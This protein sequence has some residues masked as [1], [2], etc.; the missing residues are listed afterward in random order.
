MEALVLWQPRLLTNDL[1]STRAL[2][3]TKKT[4]MTATLNTTRMSVKSM[5][6]SLGMLT[7]MR[8]WK[9]NIK[10]MQRF[11]NRV[12]LSVCLCFVCWSSL[13]V[14]CLCVLCMCFISVCRLS[15][16]LICGRLSVCLMS[17]CLMSV[18]LSSIVCLSYVCHCIMAVSAQRYL[19]SGINFHSDYD[20]IS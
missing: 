15:V 8:S 12:C 1:V 6:Q 10:L 3:Q 13:S 16:C 9:K 5:G 7:F 19:K 14:V 4:A 18:R 11:A 20:I 2:T 17:F